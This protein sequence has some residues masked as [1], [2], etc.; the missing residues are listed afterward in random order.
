MKGKNQGLLEDWQEIL[1]VS[2]YAIDNIPTLPKTRTA[3]FYKITSPL[4][5]HQALKIIESDFPAIIIANAFMDNCPRSIHKGLNFIQEARTKEFNALIISTSTVVIDEYN[6]E[7]IIAGGANMYVH[8]EPLK[9]QLPKIIEH[10]E[11]IMLCDKDFIERN[12]TTHYEAEKDI[13][14]AIENSEI[15]KK[16]RKAT[17]YLNEQYLITHFR[18][19][20]SQEK[21]KINPWRI[22]RLRKKNDG[23]GPDS[24]CFEFTREEV[25]KHR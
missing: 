23:C 8:A 25:L 20:P 16:I 1:L 11:T 15:Y 22:N 6:V 9:N 12:M 10:Y 14:E 18:K 2:P 13:K 4:K 17:F 24:F 21:T 19:N 5:S 3:G 7:R